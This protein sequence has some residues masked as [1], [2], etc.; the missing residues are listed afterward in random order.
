MEWDAFTG[1]TRICERFLHPEE[2]W[3]RWQL[4]TGQQELTVPAVRELRPVCSVDAAQ[5]RR[6]NPLLHP[7]ASAEATHGYKA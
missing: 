1:I 3:S 4:N 7:Y 5:V 2:L 6:R